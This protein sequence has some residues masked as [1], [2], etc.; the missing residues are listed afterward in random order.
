MMQALPAIAT[1]ANGSIHI[2]RWGRS[3]PRVVMVHGCAQGSKAA[4]E[5]NFAAQ[6]PLADQ[7]NTLLA[8]FITEN[9]Q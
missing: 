8:D 9:N 2:K 6:Q 3:G 4:G 1:A 5:R 7:F